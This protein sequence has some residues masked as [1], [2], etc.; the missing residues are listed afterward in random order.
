MPRPRHT[1]RNPTGRPRPTPPREPSGLSRGLRLDVLVSVVL[2]TLVLVTFAPTFQSSFVEWDDP[3]YVT[4]NPAVLAGVTWQGVEWAFTSIGNFYW[5]PLTWLSHM[6]DVQLRGLNAAGHHATSVALHAVNAVLVF[7]LLSRLTRAR[8]PSAVVAALLAVHPLQVEAVAWIAERKTVLS[9]LFGLLSVLMYLRYV[10]RPGR[11][12]YAA[13]A[14]L[15]ALGLMAKPMLVTLPIVLILLDVWPLGR[16]GSG[17]R[18]ADGTDSGNVQIDWQLSGKRMWLLVRE[19]I[20]L[21]ALSLISS[22]V[23]LLS[24]WHVGAVQPLTS[25]PLGARVAN[26]VVSSV[27]YVGLLL[28]PH[29]LA[30]FYPFRPVGWPV[31]VVCLGVLGGSLALAWTLRRTRPYLLVGGLWFLVMLLPVIGLVQV[32]GQSMADRF[33]YLPSIGLFVAAVWGVSD[34]L[35]RVAWGRWVAG[36]V[37]AMMVTACAA[38]S[39][40]QARYWKDGETLWRHA[41]EVDPRD[42]VARANLAA[43]LERE[44]KTEEALPHFIEAAR[45]LESPEGN[46]GTGR[47]GRIPGYAA[48]L[49]N[50]I[51]RLL[52]AQG[53][54]EGAVRQFS[55]AIRHQPD[56]VE[57]LANLGASDE[58]RGRFVEAAD[59]YAEAL[60]HQP[61][62]AAIRLRLGRA[63]L[64]AGRPE[65]A[66][67][68]LRQVT[69]A[70]SDWSEAH[71]SLATALQQGGNV[72]EAVTEC[73]RAVELEPTRREF[74][75]DLASLLYRRGDLAGAVE[76]LRIVV[77]DPSP[78]PG[79]ATWHYNLAAMLNEQGRRAEAVQ[80]LEAALQLRPDYPA[81]RDALRSLAGPSK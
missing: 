27:R 40:A 70:H 25:L 66:L 38:A 44:G 64:R 5:H 20:P 3:D 31:M 13:V 59:R 77:A 78:H 67:A 37:A 80:H 36:T 79:A 73:R 23:V 24:Q 18:A 63:L 14:V 43:V 17:V 6:L 65:A 69:R 34:A 71:W 81:A 22:V 72:E 55:E 32:G 75:A 10:R 57:A 42:D 28:W 15:F 68:E 45:I 30:P 51:G 2:V 54:E 26:A 61:D 48:H 7:F 16:L 29:A 47:G 12:G 46:I 8:A 52:A 39:H 74:R 11:R 19:K 49:H 35:A 1:A 56:N 33:A 58:R 41:V 76:Q 9:A 53:D 62:S 60:R 50:D 21:L 4:E